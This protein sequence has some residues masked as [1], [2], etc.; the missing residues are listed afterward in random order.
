[1]NRITDAWFEYKN[2]RSDTAYGI[3]L[4]S[5]PQR[6]IAARNSARKKVA[7]R[8]GRVR[9][10]DGSYDDITIQLKFDAR[11]ESDL[12]EI[13]AWLSGSGPLRF[14]DEPDLV[15]DA[16]IEAS[17]SRQSIR[18]RFGGQTYTVKFVCAPFKTL[19]TPAAD[20]A[21]ATSGTQITNPGTAPALPRIVIAGSGDFSLTI[22]MQ[23][24]FFEGVT[25]GG[26]IVDSLLGDALTYDGA[27]LANGKASGEL[28][29]IQPG[30]SDVS[31]IEGGLDAQGQATS[32]SVTG[33]TITPRWRYV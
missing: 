19:Y 27:L 30:A 17:P 14:S 4:L 6:T 12:P 28:F 9:F 23:K 31:W 22:G 20:I 15:Y 10:S 5:M 18:P 8:S 21:V 29:E 13:D 26:I 33:V 11:D 2:V 3:K 24:M 16:L 1:M 7:G 32:G 25:G